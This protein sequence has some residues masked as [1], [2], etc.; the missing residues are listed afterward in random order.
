MSKKD[1]QMLAN[2][3][4]SARTETLTAYPGVKEE[5]VVKLY[6]DKLLVRLCNALKADNSRFDEDRFYEAVYKG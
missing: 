3:I 6:T 2:I 1:Y 5:L 4:N